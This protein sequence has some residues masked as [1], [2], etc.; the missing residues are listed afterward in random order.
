M[1]IVLAIILVLPIIWLLVM[2][3]LG[4]GKTSYSTGGAPLPPAN[5]A[6]EAKRTYGGLGW[7]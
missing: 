4:R 7:P 1:T 6:P 5:S 2:L 3:I